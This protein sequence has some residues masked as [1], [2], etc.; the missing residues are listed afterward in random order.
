MGS[1]GTAPGGASL[2]AHAMFLLLASGSRYWLRVIEVGLKHAPMLG[3]TLFPPPGGGQAE[4]P[5]DNPLI[6]ALI[7]IAQVPFE[8][9]QRLGID[10]RQ[11][12]ESFTTADAAPDSPHWRR[13]EVKR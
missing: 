3:N 8:E 7:E 4:A 6:A 2:L 1:A 13:W 11:L 9:V 12:A 10:L 5:R